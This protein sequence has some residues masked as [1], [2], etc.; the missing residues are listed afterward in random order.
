VSAED[1]A[2]ARRLGGR[3]GA[4]TLSE[5]TRLFDGA[6]L[7]DHDGRQTLRDRFVRL[8]LAGRLGE[9]R[10]RALLATLDSAAKDVDRSAKGKAA[11]PIVVEVAKFSNA[12]EAS[13]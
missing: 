8:Y 4:M 5:I 1:K 12:A 3:R 11:D 6:D 13:E 7:G 10:Y 9:S 2:L